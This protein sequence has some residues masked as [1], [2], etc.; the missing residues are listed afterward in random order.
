MIMD[1]LWKII[2]NIANMAKHQHHILKKSL[3]ESDI[4]SLYFCINKAFYININ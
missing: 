1:K 2:E 3:L 4:K